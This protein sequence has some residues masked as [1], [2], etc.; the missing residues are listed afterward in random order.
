MKYYHIV[1]TSSQKG[2]NG[3]NG[4]GIRTATENTPREY[5]DAVI[6]GVA[7]N[8]FANVVTNC[9][10]PSPQELIDTEGAAIL[11]VPPRYFFIQL[12]VAGG[13]KVYALGRNIYVGFTETFYYKDKDGNISGKSGRMG[14]YLID[15]YLFEQCPSQEVFQILYEMPQE[16][17]NSFWPKDPSPNKNNFE[18]ASLTTGDPVMLPVE[19]KSFSAC[20]TER[21]PLLTSFLLAI[22]DAKLS[23]NQLIVRYP[24]QQTHQLI[25]EAFQLLPENSF[26]QLTF[27]T[28]YTGNGYNA[29]GD[30]LF[31]NEYYKAQYAGKGLFIDLESETYH[32][33][34]AKAFEEPIKDA[35]EQG[36]I[37]KV[38]KLL[39]WILSPAYQTLGNVSAETKS[40]MFIYNQMPN[41]FSIRMIDR[42]SNR[43]ELVS[44]LAKNFSLS[45]GNNLRFVDELTTKISYAD[46]IDQAINNIKELK[47][48]SS[49]GID[50]SEVIANKK[51]TL[52]SILMSSPQNTLLAIKNLGLDTV[53]DFT[54][55]LTDGKTWPELA[56]YLFEIWK[57][58]VPLTADEIKSK[59]DEAQNENS[60]LY[61][62]I[63]QH[64]SSLFEPFY[65]SVINNINDRNKDIIADGLMGCI[66]APLESESILNN[67]SVFNKFKLLYDVIINNEKCITDDNF[68]NVVELIGRLNVAQSE[69]GIKVK[70]KIY[71]NSSSSEIAKSIEALKKYW[72]QSTEDILKGSQNALAKN[73]FVTAALEDSGYALEKVLEIL[74]KNNISKEVKENY[75]STS[76]RY[77]SEYKSFRRKKAFCGFFRSIFS[78]FKRTPKEDSSKALKDKQEQTSLKSV[79][80]GNNSYDKSQQ[81]LPNIKTIEEPVYDQWLLYGLID[82]MKKPFYQNNGSS[83][84]N[85]A[86]RNLHDKLQNYID[87]LEANNIKIPEKFKEFK[88]LLKIWVLTFVFCTLGSIN[89]YAAD[90][91]GNDYSSGGFLGWIRDAAPWI[92][93]IFTIIVFVITFA[94]NTPDKDSLRGEI[95]DNT[96][97]RPMFMYS[98]R[99]YKFFAGISARL[100]IGL[101]GSIVI[102]L[103]IGGIVWGLLWVVKLLVWALII[104]GWICLLAGIGGILAKSPWALLIIIGGI[105][106]YYQDAL[107]DFGNSCVEAGMAFFDALNM[108]GFTQELVEQYWLHA[109]VISLS[110]LVL[111]LIAA[112]LM[113]LAAWCLRGYEAFTTHRYNVKHPCPYCHE[114]SEPAKYFDSRGNALPCTLRPSIYGLL[115]I[116]HPETG[117]QLPTLIANG[118]D[119]LVRKCP[120]CDHFINFEAGTEK[121]IGFIGMPASG[122]TS[123]LCCVIGTMKRMMSNMH[124]T[125]S[126]DENIKEIEREVSFASEHGYLDTNNLPPK[127]GAEWRASIQCILPRSNGGLPYHLYF[128]DVAGELFT[129][130][131][132]D[133]NL[134]RFSN[135]VEN[136]VFIIDPWTMKLNEQKISERVKKWLKGEE[137]EIMRTGVNEDAFTAFTS[138]INA[139]DASSRDLSKINFTFAMVKCDTGYLEGVN[140]QNAEALRG[141]MSDDLKLGNLVHAAESRFMS[142]S[143][144]ATSVLKKEDNGIPDLCNLLVK[145]LEIE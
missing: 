61:K 20:S 19:D 140:Y 89:A 67:D 40:I 107:A 82:A 108:W 32:G 25:A 131:G 8:K 91:V 96:G 137:V 111:F 133:K 54:N 88:E 60:G 41:D 129:S 76:K 117:L 24:W 69:V 48:Y 15:L 45:S 73:A 33:A 97:M 94:F 100:L 37:D 134:L 42:V 70:E 78:I 119:K 132:N 49:K 136:I 22:L 121:H 39:A 127:T 138:M 83:R 103:I 79:E 38:K 18:M 57:K 2:L 9:D 144:L 95:R 101:V 81:I 139:L 86:H 4:F 3:S 17:S 44:A 66:I 135:D 12:D 142:V 65:Q 35:F 109:L 56:P 16:G 14:T 92:L 51:D 98:L 62:T 11:R 102:M 120:H 130:G 27:S 77:A 113:I 26:P 141:F 64:F 106:V 36:N 29:P 112:A 93:L 13:R 116:T 1:Y 47:Y 85:E 6:K 104:I 84:L 46:G 68:R 5:L 74:E 7:D 123:L 90:N 50:V 143:Y 72:H 118:R 58:R 126:S 55:N 80:T 122:K 21:S 63:L 87:S 10:V 71:Q 99:P 105:V 128:N 124:F 145:Q 110:P 59:L 125:N 114:P 52:N 53:C 75:L 23:G 30:I 43:E 28:N 34:E 115:H 31:V